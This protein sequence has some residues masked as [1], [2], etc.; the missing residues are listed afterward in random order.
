[1]HEGFERM[2]E[3]AQ[4]K[5][6]FGVILCKDVPG[7]V[8][9]FTSRNIYVSSRLGI[10]KRLYVLMHEVGHVLIRWNWDKFEKE[11]SSHAGH[12]MDGRRSRSRDFKVS[13]LEEEFEAWKRGK[14]VAKR[15]GVVIDDEKFSK[16]KSSCLMS[17]INWVSEYN[18]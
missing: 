8:C 16:F 1:M 13:T 14:R 17:Y 12:Y 11:F 7:G 3:Y 15:L 4:S 9:D 18:T 5:Y 6:G 10:E 2:S